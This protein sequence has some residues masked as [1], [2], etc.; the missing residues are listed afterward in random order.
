MAISVRG[1]NSAYVNNTESVNVAL[2][3]GCAVN[4]YCL[5]FAE[6][7]W[8]AGVAPPTG[9]A[10]VINAT[11]TNVNGSLWAC[12]LT[13]AQ[14]A[15]GSVN[16]GFV[17]R[18][19]GTVALVVFVGQLAGLRTFVSA[20]HSG[21][22]LT[23]SLTTDG[24]PVAGDYALY[25]GSARFNGTVTSSNGATLETQSGFDASSILAGGSLGASGAISNTF[26]FNHSTTGDF[27]CIAVVAPTPKSPLNL[28]V[29][30]LALES[31]KEATGL[32]TLRLPLLVVEPLS[33][34]V[35]NL[36]CCLLC[37]ESL[38][39]VDP[40]G[41]VSTQIFPGTI[42]S[43]VA[44]PGL[45]FSV[46]KRPKFATLKRVAASGVSA[47]TAVRQYPIWE[48][49]FTY[50]FIS[51]DRSLGTSSLQNWIGFFLSRQGAFDTFLWKDPDDYN[52]TGGLMGTGDGVTTQFYFKRPLGGYLEK[53][54]QVD[55]GNTI[56]IYKNGVL[57][58]SG[59]TLTLPNSIVFATAPA[60]GV[61]I[62]ADFQFFY[63]GTFQEDTADY[64][65]WANQLWLEQTVILETVPQ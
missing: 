37:V 26:T 7:G 6:N 59:Y 45:A 18:Y 65:K 54:G 2:P 56:N 4:D 47:R 33:E 30:L 8:A 16:V 27:V 48:F 32:A 46:H 3:G 13:A 31:L 38:H 17:D 21:S 14:I 60:N 53:V 55:N 25:F 40:E 50:E 51:D 62:T 5:L 41:H 11:G 36:R 61:A 10:N 64:E 12:N 57:Q 22:A 19:Y 9:F 20:R 34:S 39:P 43:S 29:P 28:R 63:N 58:G 52:V 35:R 24:T 1:H 49:E 23:R 42:G 44:M 15:A